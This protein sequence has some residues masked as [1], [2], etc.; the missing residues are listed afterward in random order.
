MADLIMTRSLCFLQLPEHSK[1]SSVKTRISHFPSV[2]MV[3]LSLLAHRSYL[4]LS[5]ISSTVN[6]AA[7]FHHR[8]D[9]TSRFEFMYFQKDYFSLLFIHKTE[10]VFLFVA[11]W[12]PF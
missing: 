12:I 6:L 4:P 3:A 2:P 8:V 9:E 10:T 5:I 7:A 11:V 1:L